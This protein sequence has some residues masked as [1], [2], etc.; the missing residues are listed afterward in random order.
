MSTRTAA[1][2]A[3]FILLT[4]SPLASGCDDGVT[5][6]LSNFR[7]DGAAEDSP[8]VLLLSVD[9]YDGDGDLSGGALQT[10]IDQSP[11]SAGALDLTT[12]FLENGVGLG[13]NEG[14]LGFVLELAFASGVPESGST[15]VLGV[16]A[17]DAGGN[18]SATRELKLKLTL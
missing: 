4:L 17:T 11:T 5:P 8:L 6:N 7:F 14:S 2:A 16:R 12:L 15:F 13:A 9:F 10:F 1:R 18:T 3:L